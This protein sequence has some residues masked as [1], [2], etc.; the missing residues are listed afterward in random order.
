MELTHLHHEHPCR[1]V[2]SRPHP[3]NAKSALSKTDTALLL[4]RGGQEQHP[5]TALSD[6]APLMV[7]IAAR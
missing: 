4:P 7:T 3:A 2:P 5:V 1:L 6:T